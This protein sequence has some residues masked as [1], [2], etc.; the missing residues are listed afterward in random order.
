MMRTIILI[1]AVLVVSAVCRSSDLPMPPTGE[2]L[3]F[4]PAYDVFPPYSTN[5]ESAQLRI[6]P[7]VIR[8]ADGT[9][10]RPDAEVLAAM[11]SIV[12]TFGSYGIDSSTR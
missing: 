1:C 3:P 4:N 8:F 11:N 2:K 5:L 10:G 6:R 12:A 9:G 7:H